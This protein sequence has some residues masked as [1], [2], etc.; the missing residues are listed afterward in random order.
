MYGYVLLFAHTRIIALEGRSPRGE[1][2]KLGGKQ[3]NKP[4][5][6]DLPPPI[7]FTGVDGALAC[8]GVQGVGHR[9]DDKS[10]RSGGGLKVH[11]GL[12][13][14]Q[15]SRGEAEADNEVRSVPKPLWPTES[16]TM[17]AT[18]EKRWW[19][20]EDKMAPAKGYLKQILKETE[21]RVSSRPSSFRRCGTVNGRNRMSCAESGAP[22][23]N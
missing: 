22:M 10:R 2:P 6:S 16:S 15:S 5:H 21:R 1:R 11:N 17:K 9:P 23:A 8:N 20:L 14:R 19:A 18:F 12:A 3:S 7:R 4:G 13:E